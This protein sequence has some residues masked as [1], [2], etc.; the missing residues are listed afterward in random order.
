MPVNIRPNKIKKNLA[1][2]KISHVVSN[3]Q[4]PDS[5]DEFGTADFDGIWIE[6]DHGPRDYGAT[7][8]LSRACD[9]CAMTSAMRS[10]TPWSN[11]RAAITAQ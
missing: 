2:G 7:S 4:T 6:G 8:D 3:L 10:N 1:A 5:I 9:L 11:T